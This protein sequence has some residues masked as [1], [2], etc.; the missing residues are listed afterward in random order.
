MP[1]AAPD[2]P[3]GAAL[4]DRFCD[5]RVLHAGDRF[6]VFG[7]REPAAHRSVAVKVP[8][9]GAAWLHETL[10]A[11]AAVLAAVSAHPHVVTFFE[12]AALPDARPALLLELCPGTLDDALHR[13]EPMSLPDAVATGIKLAGA[14]E[15]VHRLGALHCDVRPRTVLLTEWGE[16]VLAG[17]DEAVWLAGA[18]TR[19]PLHQFTAHTAPELVEGGEPTRAGD[20]YG[21]ASTL[22][23]LIAG[24]A[25]FRAYA[26]ESPASVVARVLTSPVQPIFRPDVPLEVS[27]LLTWALLPDPAERPPSPAWLA[28]E[29]GRIERREGWPR[30]RFVTR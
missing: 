6:T 19:P 21:L 20:V 26:G 17:F 28:E 30:T 10:H 16:P 7:A 25:A 22:Y 5:V 3:A 14:L 12:Q 27:D 23:E 9:S 29:L 1:L 13:D 18:R 4:G 8:D 2:A 15:T 24:R 11:E